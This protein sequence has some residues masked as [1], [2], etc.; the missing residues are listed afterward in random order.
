MYNRFESSGIVKDSTF[1]NF[2]I[3]IKTKLGVPTVFV[4]IR[5]VSKVSEY[6]FLLKAK[7]AK[8]QTV[9]IVTI[10]IKMFCTKRIAFLPKANDK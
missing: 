10:I 6:W 5:G 1:D 8:K 2:H 9:L 3:V 7:N 4:F